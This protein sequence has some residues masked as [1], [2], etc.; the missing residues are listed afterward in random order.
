M[1]KSL[2]PIIMAGLLSCAAAAAVSFTGC[3]GAVEPP[4]QDLVAIEGPP[5]ITTVQPGEEKVIVV[6]FKR[7]PEYKDIIELDFE[8]APPGV[9]VSFTPTKLSPGFKDVR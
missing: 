5:G 7:G 3:G 9:D 4:P 6:T 8:D 1:P 2:R